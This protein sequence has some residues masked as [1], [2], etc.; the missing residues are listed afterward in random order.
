MMLS[1]SL[2]RIDAHDVPREFPDL[3]RQ[4]PDGLD[5][6]HPVTRRAVEPGRW[7]GRIG[8]QPGTEGKE[9][10]RQRFA[11]GELTSLEPTED[12]LEIIAVPGQCNHRVLG[13]LRF[14]G[15]PTTLPGDHHGDEADLV[16]KYFRK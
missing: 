4:R 14:A 6:Q 8:K 11:I 2:G 1:W 12:R 3:I 9:I 15:T 13:V 5:R 10:V 7:V 16:L